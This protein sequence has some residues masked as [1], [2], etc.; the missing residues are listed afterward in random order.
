MRRLLL[1]EV[2]RSLAMRRSAAK[3]AGSML[4]EKGDEFEIEDGG[5]AAAA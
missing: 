1:E 2:N 3:V 5:E 4:T